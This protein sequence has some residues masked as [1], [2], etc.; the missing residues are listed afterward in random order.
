MTHAGGKPHNV[1]D[2]GQRYE[3]TFFDP[4]R[5][6]RRTFGWSDTVDGAGAMM[7][8]IT[9]HP[10]W[11]NPRVADRWQNEWIEIPDFL[12]REGDQ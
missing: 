3:V 5:G 7:E 10:S 11:T 9:L 6:E 2:L 4:A 1:G 12:R 8:S